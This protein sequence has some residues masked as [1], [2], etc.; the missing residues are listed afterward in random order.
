MILENNRKTP[1]IKNPKDLV[2]NPFSAPEGF[3]VR[4]DS[5]GSILQHNKLEENFHVCTECQHHFS[6]G[7]RKRIELL[8][9][10]SS[11]SEKDSDI[12]GRD[13][14]NFVDSKSYGE[15]MTASQSKTNLKD[16]FV[17]AEAKLFKRPIQVGAFDFSFMG[18]SMGMAVG[19]KISRVFDRGFQKKQPVILILSSGGA[20]MHEGIL[21]LMQMAKTVN[22]MNR[23]RDK[24]LPFI[25]L[26]AHP[27]TGGVA[28]SFAF[29]ADICIAEP[30]SLIGFAGPRVIQQTINEKLPEN[31]Q[32]AEFLLEHG[33]LDCI[34]PRSQQRAYIHRML[35]LLID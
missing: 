23:F 20:R 2:N 4:C 11:M 13:V 8:C 35:S 10:S 28:A 18:G 5:C 6:L 7:A 14:L 17:S 16:A 24:K 34:V 29:L 21:S 9:D 31:F 25:S 32:R 15:R 1:G 19:E 33:M 22:S 26:F 3:W 30:K 12:E 27:T